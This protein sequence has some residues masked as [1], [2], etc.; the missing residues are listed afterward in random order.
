MGPPEPPSFITAPMA[1]LLWCWREGRGL[2]GPVYSMGRAMGFRS[3]RRGGNLV[4]PLLL[5]SAA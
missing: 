4:V 1:L 5:A 2:M 3:S